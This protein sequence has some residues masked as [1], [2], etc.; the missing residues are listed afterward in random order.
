VEGV[1]LPV[2]DAEAA[3]ENATTHAG[4]GVVPI[5]VVL[6][7]CL[8]AV[9]SG[10]VPPAWQTIWAGL[11]EGVRNTA[12][13]T[14]PLRG[15]ASTL[16]QAVLE[17]PSALLHPEGPAIYGLDADLVEDMVPQLLDTVSGKDFED[18]LGATDRIAALVTM[19]ADQS[20]DTDARSTWSLA[21]DILAYRAKAAGDEGLSASARHTS[22]AITGGYYGSEVP[23]VRVW[24]E[25]A[26][27]MMVESAR[28]MMGPGPVGPRIAS[29]RTA[30]DGSTGEA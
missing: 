5:H 30:L 17:Q 4:L 2:A 23:F 29:V 20:L 9:D 22:L 26:L 1:A 12:Q 11:A 24:V 7:F 6:G 19:A 3:F 8:R 13:L 18:G 10:V 15:L 21:L 16:D 25:R 27:A 28:T 14:D